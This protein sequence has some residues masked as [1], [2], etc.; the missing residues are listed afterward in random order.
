MQAVRSSIMLCFGQLGQQT[1]LLS[2]IA[3]CSPAAETAEQEPHLLPVSTM[4]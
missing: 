1:A 3:R 4:Q 2:I